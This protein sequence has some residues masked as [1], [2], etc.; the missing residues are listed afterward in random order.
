MYAYAMG[1]RLLG[2]SWTV[3]WRHQNIAEFYSEVLEFLSMLLDIIYIIF[4]S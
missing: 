4:V 1:S 3:L 2:M